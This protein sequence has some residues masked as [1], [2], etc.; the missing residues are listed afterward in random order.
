MDTYPYPATVNMDTYPYTS[1]VN[2]DTYPY[3]DTVNLDLHFATSIV[4]RASILWLHPDNSTY[5]N[6][7]LKCLKRTEE[8]TMFCM[9]GRSSDWKYVLITPL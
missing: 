1:T 4:A 5:Y 3:T 7:W 6:I 8:I 9:I 2:I